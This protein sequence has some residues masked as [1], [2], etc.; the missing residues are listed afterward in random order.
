MGSQHLHVS[1][2]LNSCGKAAMEK[3]V[4]DRQW[5]TD[6]LARTARP[7]QA[8]AKLRGFL[9]KFDSEIEFVLRC[10]EWEEVLTATVCHKPDILKTTV[11]QV[12]PGVMRTWGFA[13]PP[14]GKKE[15]KV[16]E[17]EMKNDGYAFKQIVGNIVS[18]QKHVTTGLRQAPVVFRLISKLRKHRG[19]T[20]EPTSV[21]PTAA[22]P[23]LV[24]PQLQTEPEKKRPFVLGKRIRAKSPVATE[25]HTPSSSSQPA[26]S[27]P[28]RRRLSFE[29]PV[30]Q[31]LQTQ[32][33]KPSSLAQRLFDEAPA[34]AAVRAA[35]IP[36]AAVPA[37][38]LAV[39]EVAV[40][41]SLYGVKAKDNSAPPVPEEAQLLLR[42]LLQPK[43]KPEVRPQPQPKPQEPKP[44]PE[45]E[46]GDAEESAE[47]EAAL[48][49]TATFVRLQVVSGTGGAW[50]VIHRSSKG[51]SYKEFRHRGDNDDDSEHITWTLYR[52]IKKAMEAGMPA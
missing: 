24:P 51:R 37:V 42:E 33:E 31:Q 17:Q 38:A 6:Q 8:T 3:Q 47:P 43:P 5:L 52:T 2:W 14:K 20:A 45:A 44:K 39:S 49:Q 7:L 22:A 34:A 18:K 1:F 50:Q 23:N 48:A 15:W 21:P 41:L 40:V 10:E 27:T 26:P 19:E 12:L 30:Y 25:A 16:W 29:S 4:S 36:A 46:A 35:A 32:A 9:F 28:T 13:D 11:W